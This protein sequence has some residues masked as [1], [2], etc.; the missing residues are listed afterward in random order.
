[1][2]YTEKSTILYTEG[3]REEADKKLLEG[4][5]HY[6]RELLALVN[7]VP[8]LDKCILIV[9]AEQVCKFLRGTDSNSDAL[10]NMLGNGL[11]T[12]VTD[13]ITQVTIVKKRREEQWS[14]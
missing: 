12:R 7:S 2:S 3:K 10:A 4:V 9:V 11:G 13:A 14:E 1:M 6:T 8:D 5:S